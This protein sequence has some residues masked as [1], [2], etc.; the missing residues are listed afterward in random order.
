MDVL[1]KVGKERS[2]CSNDV[3]VLQSSQWK[4][5]ENSAAMNL[6]MDL[7][8]RKGGSKAA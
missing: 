3:R 2:S 8:I 6:G 7:R 4:Q 5:S 1:L